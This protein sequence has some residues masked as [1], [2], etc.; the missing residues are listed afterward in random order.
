MTANVG[1]TVKVRW[2]AASPLPLV[3]G[4]REKSVTMSGEAVDITNDDSGGWRELLDVAGTNAVE[5]ACSG[6]ALNDDLREAWF[7]GER[8]A[9][10]EFEYPDGGIITGTFYLQEYAETGAHDDAVTFEATFASN[11]IVLYVGATV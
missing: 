4:I 6:V 7:N 5:I 9:A 10:A 1:R 11:G 2:G 8:M 3:A